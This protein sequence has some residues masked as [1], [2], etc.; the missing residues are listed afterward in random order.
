MRVSRESLIR[1]AK[2]NAQ[3]R[4]YN[5]HE[6]IAAYL[7]G[8]LV[9]ADVDPMIGGTADIDLV[10]VHAN[11]P[12]VRRE[13]VK[14]TADFHL[15]IS[16]R[17]RSEFKSPRDLRADPWLGYELYDPML[18]YERE[19]FFEFVQAGLRAGFEFGAP[20]L[21]L[22]RCRKL[23]AEARKDWIDL[24]DVDETK[25]G[26][27]EVSQYLHSVQNAANAIVV[28]SN[29]PSQDRRLLLDFPSRAQA[30]E[31]PEITGALLSLIGINQFDANILSSWLPDWEQSFLAAAEHPKVDLRVH[32]ARLNYYEKA[33]Q[34]ILEGDMPVAALW[35]MLLTW[36]LSTEALVDSAHEKWDGACKHLGLAGKEFVNKAEALD[37][38]ID[39][40]EVYLD[41]LATAN[42]LETS[43]S[44]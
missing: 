23:L 1:I 37:H 18:L 5:N 14:L 17:S 15:D 26:P 30:A 32:A 42:G 21:T 36:T 28:L 10:F 38:F 22:L 2:E 44:I 43:T 34:A 12:G 9:S 11:P 6:I 7:T 19:K 40:V 29:P 25:V 24:M 20:A 35:P 41:E 4:A 16:H 39:T 8:S 3:E 33:M 31:K 13:I 27:R